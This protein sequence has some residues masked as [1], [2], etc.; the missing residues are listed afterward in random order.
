MHLT[1]RLMR[2]LPDLPPATTGEPDLRSASRFLL[3]VAL[4]QRRR[5]LI[6]A[7]WGTAWMVAQALVPYAL[8]RGLDAGVRRHAMSQV[9]LW[10]L[11]ILVLS[12]AVAL[13]G[14]L[15]HRTAVINFVTAT[16]RCT[17]L[18]ARAVADLGPATRDRFSAGEVATLA[19]ADGDTVARTLDITA[20][21]SGA[22]VSVLLVAVLLVLSAPL[23][24]LVV[25]VGLP[26]SALAVAP[27]V[28]PLERR[29]GRAR[30][31]LGEASGLS[32]DLVL[33][34]RVLRGVGGE[35]LFLDRFDRASQEVRRAG[36]RAGVLSSALDGLQV[37]LPGLYVVAVTW[38]GARL[39]LDGRIDAGELVTVYGWSAF[40]L[41]PVQT[42]VEAAKKWAAATA[43]AAR[44]VALLRTPPYRT[45]P[46]LPPP[47]AAGD[48]V[49][50]PTG[51]VVGP[52]SFVAVACDDPH[53]GSALADRLGG[54]SDGAATLGGTRLAALATDD[55]RATVVVADREPVLLAGTLAAALDVPRAGPAPS[56]VEALTVAAADDVLDV[57]PTDAAMPARGRTLSGGQRQRVALAR[58][59]RT[60]APILVLDEP[61]SAVDAHTE[62]RIAG[63]LRAARAGATTVVVTTSPPLL[64]A[65]DHVVWVRDGRVAGRAS[66]HDLLRNDP[67]YRAFVTRDL[68]REHPGAH[69]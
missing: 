6:G 15:R 19:N 54:W 31:L 20:R 45:A 17:Q 12:G 5:I 18:V 64:A 62:A 42:F 49:D 2:G 44:L 26:V 7:V 13:A 29:E 1:S 48:L 10:S 35:Q 69:A 68:D 47:P 8:G 22:V 38:V 33:G 4:G 11:V 16:S 28:R 27:L 3:W 55:L 52:G 36:V 65:A 56:P 39:A 67:A 34:L 57:L 53:A 66:H 9:A 24:G 58:A 14:V 23:L 32:A 50:P 59:L 21:L 63:R 25:L 40:L 51:L 46:D 60:G 43:A 41:L 37:L 61:T 30:E